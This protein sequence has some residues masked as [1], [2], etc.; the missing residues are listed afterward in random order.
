MLPASLVS[1]MLGMVT[2]GEARLL[3]RQHLWVLGW[4][5]AK[6]NK[7]GRKGCRTWGDLLG[8]VWMSAVRQGVEL[9][10]EKGVMVVLTTLLHQP[11]S[12]LGQPGGCEGF[13]SLLSRAGFAPEVDLEVK[14]SVSHYQSHELPSHPS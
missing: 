13:P 9:P 7:A 1:E 10:G 2:G 8:R 11:R 14:V 3:C 6:G 4:G 5:R 12:E